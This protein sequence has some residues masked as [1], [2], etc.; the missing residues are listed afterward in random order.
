M[1]WLLLG[2]LVACGGKA[3]IDEGAGGAG[4][5]GAQGGSGN[6]SAQGGNNPSPTTSTSSSMPTSTGT[7]MTRSLCPEACGA[8][9]GCSTAPD[10]VVACDEVVDVC[11][12]ARDDFLE[13]FVSSGAECT[14]DQG[15]VET[16]GQYA[17]C[18]GGPKLNI[19]CGGGPGGGC[20][21]AG[22]YEGHTAETQ[23]IGLSGTSQCDCFL[24]G[25]HVGTCSH[26]GPDFE[27]CDLYKGCC[28]GLLFIPM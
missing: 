19:E 14:M 4:G 10:C 13:C 3:V 27:A 25:S 11:I 12:D 20:G 24:D 26:G 15:C 8:I 1:R 16:L 23:C 28:A 22:F 7:S 18:L 2:L 9:G 17:T 6:G 21:C 5:D